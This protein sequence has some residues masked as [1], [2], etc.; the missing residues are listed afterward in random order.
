MKLIFIIPK[1]YMMYHKAL[2]FSDPTVGAEILAAPHPRLVKAL[3]RK[4]ANFSD[5]A[6]NAHREAIVRRGNVLKFTRPVDEEDGA[7][8]VKVPAGGD[9]EEEEGVSI[10]E[11]LLRTGEREIVEASPMD[12]IWGIGF[13]A[14]RADSVRHRWGLNLLG[15]ALVAVR[16]ELR[17]GDEAKEDGNG[18]EEKKA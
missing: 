4:V 11:L 9:G 14:A 7:W 17:E 12:R 1:S 2:L 13:G 6:W 3:G 16:A 15:K 10:R 5:A 8:I 18:E